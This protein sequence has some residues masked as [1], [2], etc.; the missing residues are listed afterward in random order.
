MAYTARSN[1]IHGRLVV[2]A[3]ARELWLRASNVTEQAGP[4]GWLTALTHQLVDAL[5]V[6]GSRGMLLLKEFQIEGW[7]MVA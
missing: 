4:A 7:D 3:L 5:A 6:L 1:C 2:L